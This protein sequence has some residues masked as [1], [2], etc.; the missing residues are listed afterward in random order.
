MTIPTYNW[1]QVEQDFRQR[2]V[3]DV[4][5]TVPPSA[6]QIQSPNV[7][8]VLRLA[9]HLTFLVHQLELETKRVDRN[10]VLASVVLRHTSQEGLCEIEA[11]HPERNGRSS[12]DPILKEFQSVREGNSLKCLIIRAKSKFPLNAN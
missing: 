1:H 7:S 9:M 6:F 3:Q 11:A 12:L 4:S 2:L 10:S 5:F 8:A